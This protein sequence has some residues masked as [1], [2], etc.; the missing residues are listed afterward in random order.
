MSRCLVLALTLSKVQPQGRSKAGKR[1]EAPV[2]EQAPAQRHRADPANPTL[3]APSHATVL[4]L[5]P[6]APQ[7]PPSETVPAGDNAAAGPDHSDDGYRASPLRSRPRAPDAAEY[8]SAAFLSGDVGPG[9]RYACIGV[10]SSSQLA[11]AAAYAYLKRWA[12]GCRSIAESMI[13]IA[14][15]A[16]ADANVRCKELCVQ[17]IENEDWGDYGGTELSFRVTVTRHQLDAPP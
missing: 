16:S 10:Y 9:P 1:I 17:L 8:Y 6:A 3:P 12:R 4:P 11:W 14:E 5:M 7:L 15:R 2:A 13:G